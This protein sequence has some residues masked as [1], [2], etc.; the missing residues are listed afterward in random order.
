MKRTICYENY[1][2]ALFRPVIADI[3][4]TLNKQRAQ[5]YQLPHLFK[6]SNSVSPRAVSFPHG[7]YSI[8][9]THISGMIIHMGPL[10]DNKVSL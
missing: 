1:L 2:S 10:S 3:Q 4:V 7:S 9:M 8:S 6:G 5:W